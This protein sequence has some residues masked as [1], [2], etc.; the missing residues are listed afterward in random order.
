MC[1]STSGTP[2]SSLCAYAFQTR[3]KLYFLLDYC[4]DPTAEVWLA[5]GTTKRVD[6][7]LPTDGLLDEDGNPISIVPDTLIG[8]VT[9]PQ[10]P[11]F[12]PNGLP[13]PLG[14][15]GTLV[16]TPGGG[17]ATFT[18]NPGW[19]P[20]R[21]IVPTIDGFEEFIVSAGHALTVGADS[22]A[23]RSDSEATIKRAVAYHFPSDCVWQQGQAPPQMVGQPIPEYRNL[24]RQRGGVCGIRP[25]YWDGGFDPTNNHQ[26]YAWGANAAGHYRDP[27]AGPLPAGGW[28]SWQ[29]AQAQ[30]IADW[31]LLHHRPGEPRLGEY[32]VHVVERM[33]GAYKGQM[34]TDQWQGILHLVTLSKPIVFP[35]ND[36]LVQKLDPA[37]M[38][39]GLHSGV[40]DGVDYTQHRYPQ[41]YFRAAELERALR[42]TA[43]GQAGVYAF[44]D[45]AAVAARAVMTEGNYRDRSLNANLTNRIPYQAI[46][47]PDPLA[48]HAIATLPARVQALVDYI[49][50]VTAWVVGLWLTDGGSD[51]THIAQSLATEG[52]ILNDHSGVFERCRHWLDL[53]GQPP[54]TVNIVAAAGLGDG[55]N[56]LPASFLYFHQPVKGLGVG[57]VN[58]LCN[59]LVRCGVVVLPVFPPNLPPA[60]RQLIEKT[61][62]PLNKPRFWGRGAAQ[63][64]GL[65]ERDSSNSARP[66]RW[67]HRRAWHPRDS[68]G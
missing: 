16:P 66:P 12:L 11:P 33:P 2:T 44:V 54:N 26:P 52:G 25:Y 32:P 15:P 34:E 68:V 41:V 56:Q 57:T 28:A 17:G 63:P 49:L 13:N 48:L 37:M 23:R 18:V 39:G 14:T 64:S 30:Q 59:L 53:L 29:A 43:A 20:K 24:T 38:D 1:W 6:E 60:Q 51:G 8:T 35:V 9:F 65:A 21:R 45:P 58:V 31:N 36:Y 22:S 4:F 5:D 47:P 7:L 55:A 3:H 40:V 50:E 67:R 10:P 46:F 61:A 19:Q 27:R 62:Q 42:L